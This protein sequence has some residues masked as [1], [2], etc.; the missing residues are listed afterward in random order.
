MIAAAP[1]PLGIVIAVV[2]LVAMVGLLRWMF[3]V[4]RPVREEV[5]RAHRAPD[6]LRR[7]LVAT[8]GTFESQRAVELACRLGHEQQAE[9]ILVYVVEVP[10]TLGLGA[11]LPGVE[12]KAREALDT[13]AEIVRL[14]GLEPR[15]IVWR[16]RLSGDGV[17]AAARDNNADII[18]IGVGP[19]RSRVT[20]GW[21]RTSDVLLQRAPC[22]VVFDKLPEGEGRP[23]PPPPTATP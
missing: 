7:I 22:E 23:A 2:F 1:S 13:A 9:I 14:H 21:G 20:G 18:V 8:I 4:P 19:R 17:I 5:A 10:R 3:R 15:P 12:E 6:I 16:A 11:S